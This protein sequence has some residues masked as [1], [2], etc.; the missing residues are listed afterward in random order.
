MDGRLRSC[1]ISL[2][3]LWT[4]IA[5]CGR[6]PA[7][8]VEEIN[9]R[10]DLPEASPIAIADNDWPWWRG[11]HRNNTAICEHAA[12]SWSDSENVLWKTP[13]A[14]R[15]H[16]TPSIVGD[17]IYL[18][19]ADEAA[20]KQLVIC[21]D[22][23]TGKQLWSTEV[24]S[25][26]FA[27]RSEMHPK[28][29][30]ANASVACDGHCLFIG[31]L[32]SEH[33]HAT[34]L[35]LDGEILWRQDLGYFG[36]KFGFAPSPC[37]VGDLVVFAADNRGGGFIAALHRGTGDIA[38]RKARN[39]VDT[40]SPVIAAD[41]EGETQLLISGDNRVAAYDPQTGDELWSCPGTA[42]ATCGSVVW[43]G[44]LVFASGGYPDRQTVCV[45]ATTGT[46]IWEDT[47]KCYEQSMLV[48]GDHLYCVN[49]DGI[50]MCRD[51]TTGKM[52]WRHRLSGSIS[53]SPV[54][55]GNLIYATNE[56]GTTWVF[57]ANPDSY[58]QVAQ[59]QLGT[60]SFAS[61]AIC[62]EQIFARVATGN[63]PNRQEYVYCITS[64]AIHPH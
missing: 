64:R 42:E 23:A 20:E 34:C 45:D 19:T 10:T 53:A 7:K 44:N 29:T 55:V 47:V 22:R 33:I 35:S 46:K 49:D 26:G 12:T 9:A 31:F 28:S 16:G 1:L 5:G 58:K 52:K 60:E 56:A 57:E 61:L 15:G 54:L 50:A 59:N 30:H 21:L 18:S 51:I 39:N 37:I 38:W 24:H 17:R 62:N 6:P 2:L 13:I 4:T 41:I 27:A 63:G 8:P 48:A 40:Y 43:H 14:G 36:S 32:N 11:I 25:A 3:G